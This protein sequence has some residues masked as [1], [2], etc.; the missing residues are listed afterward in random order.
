M[1]LYKLR[2][3]LLDAQQLTASNVLAFSDW[4]QG[5]IILGSVGNRAPESHLDMFPMVRLPDERVVT[6]TNWV[7][8]NQDT[9]KL[10]VYTDEQFLIMHEPQMSAASLSYPVSEHAFNFMASGHTKKPEHAALVETESSDG[11]NE[12]VLAYGHIDKTAFTA[13]F[14]TLYPDDYYHAPSSQVTHTYA[15]LL[16]VPAV[17]TDS[18]LAVVRL[19]PYSLDENRF[20]VTA[21]EL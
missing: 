2:S 20:P 12:W 8:K 14:Q 3:P 17:S 4:V 18:A 11:R 5:D 21:V 7:T 1:A 19:C 15:S 10:L 6:C 13:A 16:S 9:N